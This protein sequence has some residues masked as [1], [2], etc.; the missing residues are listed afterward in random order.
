[1]NDKVFVGGNTGDDTLTINSGTGISNSSDYDVRM[2]GGDDDVFISAGNNILNSLIS[3]DGETLANDG[4]DSFEVNGPALTIINSE[5]RGMGGQ[6][7]IEI[8][9][10]SNS[11]INGNSGNDDINGGIAST[12]VSNSSIYGGQGVDTI[13][14]TFVGAGNE[15]N[16]NKGNDTITVTGTTISSTFINGGQGDDSVTLTG[17]TID[18]NT[19]SG[20]KG[21]D[22]V[23]GSDANDILFGGDGIDNLT[24]LDGADTL[25]GGA[26]S[27]TFNYVGNDEASVSGNTGFDTITD[28]AA[29]AGI[30]DLISFAFG[31]YTLDET[32][33]TVA[34]G[35]AG[36]TLEATLA[37]AAT[38]GGGPIVANEVQMVRISDS[39]SFAGDYLVAFANGDTAYNAG[40]STVINVNGFAGLT[41]ASIS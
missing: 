29:S 35:A 18:G 23:T 22:T 4:D 26:G 12:S 14:V 38:Y 32:V 36:A 19:I 37:D 30:G 8:G 15:V 40:T 2:G 11:I 24:G 28:L 33:N 6:D 7:N 17:A 5:I 9:N 10:L 27:D 20:D 31:V 1:L 39:V 25:T 21:N 13:N 3:L 16:G 41:D 34:L